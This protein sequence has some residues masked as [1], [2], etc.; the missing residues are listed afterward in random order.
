MSSAI[1]FLLVLGAASP[2]SGET[3]LV[4]VQESLDGGP[5]PLPSPARE[6]ILAGI[7]DRGH[8]IFDVPDSVPAPPSSELVKMAREGGAGLVLE[9]VVEFR[10]SRLA[11][12]AVRVDASARY[13]VMDASTGRVRRTGAITST[14]GGREKEVDRIALGMEVGEEVAA[15]IED[16]LQE[17]ANA[18]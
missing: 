2:L 7:F 8:I 9:A 11:G 17:S 4:A 16:I 18:Q 10:E 13:T 5:F 6:G 3:I 14:N 1:L 12:G 15:V